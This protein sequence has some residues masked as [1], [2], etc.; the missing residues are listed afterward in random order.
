M[1]VPPV[2]SNAGPLMALACLDALPLLEQAYTIV[3]IRQAVQ[4]ELTAGNASGFVVPSFP[5]LRVEANAPDNE[6]GLL[7]ELDDGEAHSILLARRMRAL[8]LV[9]ERLGRRV[10]RHL[11]VCITGTV[12]F[13][14]RCRRE[15]LLP[16][17]R[18]AAR[19]LEVGGVYLSD[20]LI[21]EVAGQ[22]G[23]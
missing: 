1:E 8:L 18:D 10:A 20:T 2:V 13:L 14:A 5:W 16:S 23:E 21:D 15:G 4:D 17:F 9:D 12:G 7:Y 11:G 19:R 3:H 22:L 6:R